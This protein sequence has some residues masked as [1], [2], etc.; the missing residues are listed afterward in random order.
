M[1]CHILIVDDHFIV[2]RMLKALLETHEGWQVCWEAENGDEAVAR[3]SENKPDL[4]I[5][6]VAMPVKDGI[7]ASREI[8]AMAPT[9]PIV[10]YT[11][12]YSPQLEL[13]AK[14]VGVRAVVLKAESGDELLKTIE[15]VLNP[16]GEPDSKAGSPAENSSATFGGEKRKAAAQSQSNG[17]PSDAPNSNPAKGS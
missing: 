9:V 4:I 15:T 11:L 12:H 14:K 2:R 10:M 13:E 6:D 3:V 5:M 16:E 7:R 8:S 1:P 17:D